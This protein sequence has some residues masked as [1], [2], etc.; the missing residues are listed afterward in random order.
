MRKL[1]L[2]SVL[3]TVFIALGSVLAEEVDIV[4]LEKELWADV[5]NKKLAEL[6]AR[7]APGFRM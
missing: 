2:F 1:T 4:K 3:F 6:E 7:L 5:K